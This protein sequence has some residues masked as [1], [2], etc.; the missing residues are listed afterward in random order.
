MYN[1]EKCVEDCETPIAE[2]EPEIACE[3]VG[4]QNSIQSL[5]ERLSS[6]S[7]RLSPILQD[8]NPTPDSCDKESS[9]KTRLGKEIRKHKEE[10]YSLIEFVSSIT[11]RLEL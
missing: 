9:C 8:E 4:L 7:G 10:I 1:G 3:L 11:E 5:K 6:L 2:R